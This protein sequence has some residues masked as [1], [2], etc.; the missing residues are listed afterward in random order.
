MRLCLWRV[1]HCRD[2]QCREARPRDLETA[3]SNDQTQTKD[4]SLSL[5]LD[6]HAYKGTEKFNIQSET[7]S[8]LSLYFPN[9]GGSAVYVLARGE[10]VVLTPE[11]QVHSFLSNVHFR[12]FHLQQLQWGL[13]TSSN[14][15]CQFGATAYFANHGGRLIAYNLSLNTLS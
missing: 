3:A 4:Q 5:P 10:I 2:G 14:E 15:V 8:P 11:K 7:Y 12:D 6:I 13:I 1:Q 9:S